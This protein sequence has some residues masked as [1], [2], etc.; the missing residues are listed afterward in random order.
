MRADEFTRII[1][2]RIIIRVSQCEH[3][4]KG[5]RT[6]FDESQNRFPK[7]HFCLRATIKKSCLLFILNQTLKLQP[8]L[9]K[10]SRL[11]NW[12]KGSPYEVFT[13]CYFGLGI[14]NIYCVGQ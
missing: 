7:N 13:I 3:G 11:L 1:E 12:L 5:W 4:V 10:N 6:R 14:L 8:Q 2:C 9:Q